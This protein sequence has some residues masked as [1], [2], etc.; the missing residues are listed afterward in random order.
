M[1]TGTDT[2]TAP[3]PRRTLTD[4]HNRYVTAVVLAL[5]ALVA[6]AVTGIWQYSASYLTSVLLTLPFFALAV[7]SALIMP[8]NRR[9]RTIALVLLVGVFVVEN[10]LADIHEFAAA[11]LRL[12]GPGDFAW[13]PGI[14]TVCLLTSAWL[15][16]RSRHA[17]AFLAAL[18]LRVALW[19]GV[20]ALIGFWLQPAIISGTEHDFAVALPLL[21]VVGL[22]LSLASWIAATWVGAFIDSAARRRQSTRVAADA[23]SRAANPGFVSERTN[24]LAIAS[25]IVVFF[26]SIVGLIL[27]HVA[28][29]QINRTGEHGRGLALAAVI[30]GWVSTG[31]S[32]LIVI[33]AIAVADSN[34]QSGVFPG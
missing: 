16:L 23:V 15:R 6:D 10:G 11:S 21:N 2:F 1:T 12:A 3:A 24:G 5:L 22:A 4:A 9:A 32:M 30:I 14:L 13:V 31:L 8:A 20:F 25:L 29:G 18:P 19:L 27:G 26:S 34:G 28:L 17:L 7:V 33:I